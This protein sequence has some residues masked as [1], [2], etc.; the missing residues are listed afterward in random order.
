MHLVHDHMF[1]HGGSIIK[2]SM[3]ANVST[4][5]ISVENQTITRDHE[6]SHDYLPDNIWA[7]STHRLQEARQ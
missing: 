3:L 2:L 7:R 6:R 5:S 4:H 1:Y